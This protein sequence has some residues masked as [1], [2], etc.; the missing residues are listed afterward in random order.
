[1]EEEQSECINTKAS[2]SIGWKGNRSPA[3]FV[4]FPRVY[5]QLKDL[6]P[7]SPKY[8]LCISVYPSLNPHC[9][10][11]FTHSIFICFYMVMGDTRLMTSFHFA[12]CLY[13]VSRAL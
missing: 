2:S 11:S 5:M 9:I 1:M 6:Y 4:S 13:L 3:V 7:I 8:A 12:S 10:V